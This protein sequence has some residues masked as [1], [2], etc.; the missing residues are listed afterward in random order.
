ML[1][2]FLGS[3]KYGHANIGILTSE[4]KIPMLV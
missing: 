4:V 2:G 1:G 3:V